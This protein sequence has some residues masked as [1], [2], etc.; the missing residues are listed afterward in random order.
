M[1]PKTK[2]ST[3]KGFAPRPQV[4]TSTQKKDQSDARKKG[5]EN[6]D[7]SLMLSSSEFTNKQSI[8]DSR[9]A[10]LD[11]ASSVSS[12]STAG[13]IDLLDEAEEESYSEEGLDQKVNSEAAIG[14]DESDEFGDKACDN[15]QTLSV[16]D[17]F[18]G[19]V[20]SEIDERLNRIRIEGEA[21]SEEDDEDVEIDAVAEI[22]VDITEKE[23]TLDPEERRRML[24]DLAREHFEK[25]TK[26]FTFPS[27]VKSDE[28]IEIFLNRSLSGLKDE[29]DVLIKGAFNGWRWKFFT[30][31]LQK[32]ELK[33]DWWSCQLYV[34]KQAYRIDFVFFNG[35][36][37]YEN[38]DSKDFFLPVEGTMDE[39]AFE[40][41]LLEEKRKELERIAAEEAE[42]ERRAKEQRKEE[43]ER[44]ARDADRAQAKVEVKKKQEAFQRMQ[45]L[46]RDSL[47]NVWHIE[48][49]LF[50][51]GDRIRLYYNR[52]SRPLQHS[53]EIW[54]HGGH[55]IWSEG[56]SIVSRLSPSEKRDGDWWYA[57]GMYLYVFTLFIN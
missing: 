53:T 48:P 47:E 40:D 5:E 3:P 9:T 26:L 12:N 22:D 49:S 46:A 44:A 29:P 16:V 32:T 15:M 1:I 11:S 6:P 57:D 52:S 4:E 2:G 33:G 42:R 17:G 45:N 55:N 14:I 13:R 50:K 35:A 8:N 27:T 18:E 56:L 38:N 19:S 36:N 39:K 10:V 54:I 28:T 37:V 21:S 24:E 31:R 7:G 23:E 20:S 30:E 25:G 51:G 41:F 43:E 34:Y